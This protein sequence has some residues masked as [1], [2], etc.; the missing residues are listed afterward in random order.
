MDN[1]KERDQL[2]DSGISK[3]KIR[4]K[5]LKRNETHVWHKWL[6]IGYNVRL[7]MK[8]CAPWNEK[9]EQLSNCQ[10]FKKDHI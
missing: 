9:S 2:G 3:N 6:R 7:L 1:L 4:L 5:L 10:L 8:P